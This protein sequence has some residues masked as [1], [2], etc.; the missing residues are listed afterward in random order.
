MDINN[1]DCVLPTI[2]I[3]KRKLDGT[4][5]LVLVFVNKDDVISQQLPAVK[6]YSICIYHG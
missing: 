6:L 2:D 3:I 1:F 4:D 5:K